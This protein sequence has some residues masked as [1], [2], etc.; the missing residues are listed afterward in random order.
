VSQSWSILIGK[1]LILIVM[2][3]VGVVLLP[4]TEGFTK[5][6]TTVLVLAIFGLSYWLMA[7]IIH[8]GANL[9]ILIPFMGAVIPLATVVFG[10]VVYGEGASL[11][12]VALL[13]FAC[14]SVGVASRL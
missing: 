6:G 11:A 4:R 13:L 8:S 5:P 7:R 12:R 10:I 1:F 3:V 9:G 14:V 2:Q